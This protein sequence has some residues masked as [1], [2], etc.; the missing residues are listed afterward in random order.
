[1]SDERKNCH[2]PLPQYFEKAL[3]EAEKRLGANKL[4]YQRPPWKAFLDM[5]LSSMGWRMG[6]GETFPMRFALGF[7]R[8]SPKI[9]FDFAMKTQNPKGGRGFMTE[10]FIT[11]GK[12]NS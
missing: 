7:A 1:M 3:R 12:A 4:D 6:A 9:K 5:P 2:P 10:L 11:R 8:F